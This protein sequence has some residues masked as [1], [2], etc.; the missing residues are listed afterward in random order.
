MIRPLLSTVS[1]VVVV[2]CSV[3]ILAADFALYPTGPSQDLSLIH[4]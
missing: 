1:G 3:N 4:I 2:L